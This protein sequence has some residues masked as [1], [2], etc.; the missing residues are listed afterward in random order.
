MFNRQ[1]FNDDFALF[2]KAN[3]LLSALLCTLFL[4]HH[5]GDG[6]VAYALI[7]AA[8]FSSMALLYFLYYLLLFLLQPLGRLSLYVGALLFTV[9]D[10]AL[11][12]DFFIYR[13][14]KFHINAMVWNILTSPEASDS[15]QIGTAPVLLLL[16]S[17][18]F[19]ALVQYL[20]IVR[21]GRI[22]GVR[23]AALNKKINRRVAIPLLSVMV[24]EKLLYA[25]ASLT[26]RS[27]LLSAYRVVPLYQPLTFNKFAAKYFGYKPDVTVANTIHR[28]AH[29]HYP[30]HE[31]TFDETAKKFN[32]FIFA[33]DAVRNSEI[34]ASTAP[35]ITKFKEEA[36]TFTNHYSGGNATRFG[37]FSLFYGLNATYWFNFLD[38]RRGALFFDVLKRMG[39]DF[40]IISST[41]TNWPEFRKT[42]YVGITDAIIDRFE[43]APWQKDR[44]ACDAF[45]QK[46]ETFGA[47]TPHFAFVFL[48]A[49]H[50]YSFPPEENLFHAEGENINY[51]NATRESEEIESAH[52]GY[53]NA[54]HF[55]DKLFGE[56]LA[57]LKEKGLYD[58][59]LIIITSDH[60]QEF[61]EYGFFGHN[62]AFS[63]AQ[64]NALFV[65][66]LPKGMEGVHVPRS[67]MTSHI[68]LV[69]TLLTMLG[70]TNPP[71]DYSNGKNMFDPHFHRDYIFCANWNNNAII[72]PEKSYIFSN[73]PN[74]MFRNEVR[75]TATYREIPGKSD[76]KLTL[77]VIEENR[78]F[79]H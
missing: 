30:L 42:C 31:I 54:I 9:T 43:G 49:P 8:A 67:E 50:G 44:Q 52:A 36:L 26:N 19:L 10:I 48:D 34:N 13:L 68:D 73:L 28:K 76:P 37:I 5:E 4:L 55:D 71:K 29:L 35:N 32:I 17:I 72:T 18:V 78:R 62:S 64:T 66:K 65:M 47:S 3:Y 21:I 59:A 7:V 16:I 27:D 63:R 77:H 79:L 23:K 15:L 1:I 39:Y 53:R 6:I 22:K 2:W 57:K 58:D 20:L 51:L 41:N 69:P 38:A 25:T 75:D 46:A 12:V 60:G 33:S 70:V 24:G 61:Y 45:L 40:T 14:Y 74:K 11:I 56:M